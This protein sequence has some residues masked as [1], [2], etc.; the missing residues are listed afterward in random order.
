MTTAQQIIDRA[1]RPMRDPDQEFF[2]PDEM[3]EYLNEAQRDVAVRQ[4]LFVTEEL[5]AVNNGAITSSDPDN[6]AGW[7]WVRDSSGHELSWIDPSLFFRY[8]ES[9]YADDTIPFVTPV[10]GELRILPVPDNGVQYTL[11]YVRMPAD[12]D[13]SAD[14]VEVPPM[15]HDKL[16]A[17]LRA[18]CYYR[19]D[20][21]TMGD[22]E[23]T[24][25]NMGL[26]EP[27][28]AYSVNRPGR[29][30]AAIEM[31]VFDDDPE[32]RH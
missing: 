14:A 3:Y 12:V 24:R 7:K 6:V 16:V 21:E 22:R 20:N 13:D 19:L 8:Q 5:V 27:V 32:R 30:V 26:V 11:G 9:D 4:S 28:R 2:L 15:Y 18:Q 23:L 25:Y 10:E 29:P 1:L 17:Y 31:T